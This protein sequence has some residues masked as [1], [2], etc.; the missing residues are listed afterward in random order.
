MLDHGMG[1]WR[2]K[3]YLPGR[4]Q[5]QGKAGPRDE[6]LLRSTGERGTI[7]GTDLLCLAWR[8]AC[9]TGESRQRFP[10]WLSYRERPIGIGTDVVI[11]SMPEANAHRAKLRS[12]A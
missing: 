4:R 1:S 12:D 6:E 3:P 7:T 10:V 11:A 9:G 8:L 5:R 2:H